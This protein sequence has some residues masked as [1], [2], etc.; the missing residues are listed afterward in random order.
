MQY[1]SIQ[2]RDFY[3]VP[4]MF[5]VQFNGMTYL[6]DCPFDERED[7]YSTHYSVFLMPPLD[8]ADLTGDWR[9]L[10]TMAV[11]LIGKVLV[12]D[13]KFDASKRNAISTDIIGRLL[14]KSGGD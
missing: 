8:T 3:D 5:I 6:F 4:R 7:E 9:Q 13:V 14:K 1:A 12:S 10:P 2:Y 11:Q